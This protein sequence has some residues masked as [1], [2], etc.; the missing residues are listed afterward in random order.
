MDGFSLYNKCMG[1]LGRKKRQPIE[2]DCTEVVS[3]ERVMKESGPAIPCGLVVV[4]AG[5]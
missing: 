1:S 3:I 5:K 4:R 2:H